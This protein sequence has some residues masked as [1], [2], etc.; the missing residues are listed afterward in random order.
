[1]NETS[2]SVAAMHNDPI[3]VEQKFHLANEEA[4][5]ERLHSIGGVELR[6]EINEDHYFNHPAKDFAQ[7]REALRVR[8]INGRGYVTYKG[9]KM[10][11]LIKARRELEWCLGS[12]DC[13]GTKMRSLLTVLD[14]RPVAVVKKTRR[15][16]SIANHPQMTIVLDNVEGLG[17]FIEI[18]TIC[19]DLS[20]V[21]SA[22]NRVLEL[23]QQ[24]KLDRPEPRSYLSML[25]QSRE[26]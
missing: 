6:H 21:E 23:A 4:F 3:E 17:K 12:D 13:D 11:G 14:F 15:V 2:G 1:M 22:R 9:P 18:E 5:V 10:P 7:T 25:L 20:E 16:F 26:V 19:D 24:L 8:M